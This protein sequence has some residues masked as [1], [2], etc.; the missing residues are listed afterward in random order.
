MASLN[1]PV[2]G[3]WSGPIALEFLTDGTVTVG[4][5]VN[6]LSFLVWE[7]GTDHKL[8]T[9]DNDGKRTIYDFARSDTSLELVLVDGPDHLPAGT[10]A[11]R[12]GGPAP[13]NLSQSPA[14]NVFIN[15]W[16]AD[17]G[18]NWKW[19]LQY[20]AEGVVT[21]THLG[22]HTFPNVYMIRTNPPDAEPAGYHY[23]Y[24]NMR[25]QNGV[26]GTYEVD[27]SGNP[28]SVN[29]SGTVSKYTPTDSLV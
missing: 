14:A 19:N 27:A 29:E 2:I 5:A 11:F 15:S 20:T 3:Q 21:T 22:M 7:R 17:G 12:S 24:G 13:L 8:I 18:G 16:I 9:L 1:C 26:L 28:V 10:Y 6:E 25:Y 23:I 4:S